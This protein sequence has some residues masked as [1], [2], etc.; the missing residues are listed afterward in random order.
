[1]PPRTLEEQ[2]ERSRSVATS[3][4]SIAIMLL[5]AA[6][7]LLAV[8]LPLRGGLGFLFVS[9]LLG[10]IGAVALAGG[11][12]FHLVPSRLEALADE[13]REHDRRDRR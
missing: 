1:M 5:G 3:I 11:F 13:K 12:F 9:I 8:F 2:R 7:L 6:F 4:V 10:G